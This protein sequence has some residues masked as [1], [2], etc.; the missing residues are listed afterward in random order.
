MARD[1]STSS[2][3]LILVGWRE[4][5]ALP[6]LG[7]PAIKTKIDTGARTS[8]L[9]VEGHETFVKRGQRW[10]RFSLSPGSRRAVQ[11]QVCEAPILDE[12]PVTDS[13]GNTAPR[14]F[15]ETRVAVGAW[16]WPIE[17]NLTDRRSMLFPMLLGRTAMRGRLMVDP[18]GSFLLGRPSMRAQ[19][20]ITA[21][22]WGTP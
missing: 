11:P 4:W 15:I 21:A 19:Q 6:D 22:H 8:S 14:L 10:V 16:S 20:L 13:S 3:E 7:M 9:H 18:N 1:A 2:S 5:L 12:R 17:M